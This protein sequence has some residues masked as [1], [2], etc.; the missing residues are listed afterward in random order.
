MKINFDA[1]TT[2]NLS[3]GQLAHLERDRWPEFE[4]DLRLRRNRKVHFD[5]CTWHMERPGWAWLICRCRKWDEVERVLNKHNLGYCWKH[6]WHV[7]QIE[8]GDGEVYR[9]S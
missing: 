1:I 3:A 9:L 5:L 8:G 7:M 6:R 2:E 4:R